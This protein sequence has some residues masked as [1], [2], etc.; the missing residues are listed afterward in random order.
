MIQPDEP[1]DQ[2]ELLEIEA[3]FSKTTQTIA[4]RDLQDDGVWR[5]GWV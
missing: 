1:T 5:K 2:I 3:V 4:W